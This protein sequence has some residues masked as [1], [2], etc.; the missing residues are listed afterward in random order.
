VIKLERIVDA[1]AGEIDALLWSFAYFFC[2]L[3]SYY[4]LRPIREEMGVAG[5][6]DNLPWLFTGTF[7]AMLVAIPLYSAVVARFPRRRIIPIVYR[8]F[9]LNLLVFFVLLRLDVS[10]I[11][12]GRVFFIWI[13]VFNLFVVSIF[14]SFMADIFKSEQGKRLFGFIAAGGSAGALVGPLLTAKLV[15][16]LGPTN[17]FLVSIV[18]LEA[19]VLCV[20]QLDRRAAAIARAA[21][22]PVSLGGDPPPR[23]PSPEAEGRVGGGVFGGIK[24]VV[25]SGY[26]LGICVQTLFLTTTATFL[27]LQQA[28]IVSA[29]SV[30]PA[31]RTAMFAAID[32]TANALTIVVQALL[33]GRII[34]RLG[35]AFSLGLLPVLTGLGFLGL[36]VAPRVSVLA[37]FQGGRRAIHYAVE[38][39]AREI[40]FTVVGPEAKYKS[41][42]FIDTVVYRGGDAAS[43]WAFAGLTAGLGLGATA[44]AL[45]TVPMAGAWLLVTR[46]LARKQEALSAREDL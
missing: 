28:R 25:Q 18:L 46:Y 4:I 20:R 41:K 13:S 9:S 10:R 7:A 23:P 5:G 38:R 34:T 17:L 12:V 42:S 16:P 27:Y 21:L 2:L 15:K 39:P 11:H 29:S 32:L 45:I 30:D 19:G 3:C 22:A 14:W 44:M 26:L 31:E 6:V 1:K 33:T 43:G 35:L 37:V 40:L 8:F 36:A 24:L